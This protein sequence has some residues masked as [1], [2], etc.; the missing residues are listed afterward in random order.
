MFEFLHPSDIKRRFRRTSDNPLEMLS[1]W[2]IEL[3]F[4]GGFVAFAL[5]SPTR[6]TIALGLPFV[7][8]GLAMRTWAR[9]HLRRGKELAVT[10][11]Y[12]HHRHPL[13][14]GSFL[15]GVGF[16][17]MTGAPVV[18]VLFPLGFAAMYVPKMLREEA[19]LRRTYGERYA[20]YA[21][22][23]PSLLPRLSR[24]Q[25]VPDAWEFRWQLVRRHRE[26]RT[27]LGAA[28]L[29]SL[30]CLM[31]WNVVPNARHLL[32]RVRVARA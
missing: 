15:A 4:A 26:W 27:W 16:A 11:P 32:D 23:V 2:R 13:Y 29:L 1:R 24:A 7:V 25:G 30:F 21:A 10:G 17:I 31:A 5:A 19:W 20:R 14:L 12:A 6:T 22:D 8:A 9:G 18:A 28:A 3:G